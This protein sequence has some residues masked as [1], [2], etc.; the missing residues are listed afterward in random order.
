MFSFPFLYLFSE[1]FSNPFDVLPEGWVRVTHNTGIPIYLHKESR[2]C[3]T[4]PPYF[5]GPGSARVF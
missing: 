5:L 2:V 1:I 3:T 4:A